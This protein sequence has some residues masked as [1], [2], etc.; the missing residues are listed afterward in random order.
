MAFALLIIGIFLL[1]SAIQGTQDAALNL[2]VGDF[3]GPSNFFYWIV[4][5]LIVG[6]VGYVKRLKPVSDLFL[7][8]I[9]LVLVL[10]RGNPSGAG[11]GFFAQFTAA[12][13]STSASN[14]PN[15]GATSGTTNG[16]PGNPNGQGGASLGN[17][18]T[19]TPVPNGGTP[20]T[21]TPCPGGGSTLTGLC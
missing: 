14:I 7:A 6:S 1:A 18:Q 2:V 4:A 5:L 3:K 20:G 13:Q 11:G 16:L 12:L 19:P 9:I 17:G 15:V 8:L 21:L 10:K